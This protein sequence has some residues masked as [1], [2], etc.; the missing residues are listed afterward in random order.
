[1]HEDLYQYQKIRG[2]PAPIELQCFYNLDTPNVVHILMPEATRPESKYLDVK[3]QNSEQRAKNQRIKETA[4]LFLPDLRKGEDYPLL[5]A[6]LED[7]DEIVREGQELTKR[8]LRKRESNK[9]RRHNRP[10]EH[11]AQSFSDQELT[12]DASD[13]DSIDGESGE[14][15]ESERW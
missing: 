6:I 8:A 9:V 1:M 14:P 11:E 4:R 7:Q 2:E 12:I 5:K 10:V 3:C 13:D 15:M